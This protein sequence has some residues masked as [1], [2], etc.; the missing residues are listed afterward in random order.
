MYVDWE[1]PGEVLLELPVGLRSLMMRNQVVSK[2]QM[3]I[4]LLAADIEGVQLMR[5]DALVFAPKIATPRNTPLTLGLVPKRFQ[6]SRPV[7]E[8]SEIR[9]FSKHIDDRLRAEAWDG[10]ATDVVNLNHDVADGVPNAFR[11]G[12][13]AGWPELVVWHDANDHGI[14]RLPAE[15][16]RIEKIG[17]SERAYA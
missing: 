2:R 15:S 10:R 12:L 6:C 7:I 14:N 4:R 5:S 16:W 13:V 11:F 9:H 3:T 1:A 17:T 8:L